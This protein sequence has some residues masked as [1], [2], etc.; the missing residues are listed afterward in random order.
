MNPRKMLL[1]GTM[2][3]TIAVSGGAAAS[4]VASASPSKTMQASRT[5]SQDPNQD[6]LLSLLGVSDEEMFE[7][8]YNGRSLAQVAASRQ[9]DAKKVIELQVAQLTDQ[10]R[11]RLSKGS[12][13]P[14]QYLG[15]KSEIREIVRK[16]VLGDNL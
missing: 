4:S 14:E 8:L 11:L 15:Q 3:F 12:L 2:A 5:A 16:S 10:L 13:S 9:V 7:S 6:E 1:N